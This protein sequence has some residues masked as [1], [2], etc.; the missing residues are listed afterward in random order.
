MMMPKPNERKDSVLEMHVE[1]RHFGKQRTLVE[2][3]KRYYWHNRTAQVRANVKACKEC[4]L[5]RQIGSIMSNVENLK[6]IPI[7]DLFYKITLDIA[8]PLP[9]TNKG[10]KYILIAIDH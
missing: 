7:C 4:Q 10:N 9:E 8:G 3:Y 6:N 5:V 2:I 1:N